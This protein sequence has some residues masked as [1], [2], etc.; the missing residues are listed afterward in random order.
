MDI[1]KPDTVEF[2]E[3]DT[4]TLS[5][6]G[7]TSQQANETEVDNDA[8]T[9]SSSQSSSWDYSPDHCPY[10]FEGFKGLGDCS[11]Y[12]ECKNM[13][14]GE[15][16]R[17]DTG[18]RFAEDR[19]E[20]IARELVDKD[21]NKPKSS[22]EG[23]G[24]AET[25]AAASNDAV[26]HDDP[27]EN[28]KSQ[29]QQDNSGQQ[30][31]WPEGMPPEIYDPDLCP[32]EFTGIKWKDDCSVY[33][34]CDEGYVGDVHSCETGLKFERDLGR[35]IHQQFVGQDYK[36]VEIL[37]AG[38]DQNEEEEAGGGGLEEKEEAEGGAAKAEVEE[39]VEDA[40]EEPPV[41]F[42]SLALCPLEIVGLHSRGDCTQ[43]YKCE[44]GY[45]IGL[46]HS[47]EDGSKFDKHGGEC[48]SSELVDRKCYGPKPDEDVESTEE[49]VVEFNTVD[50]QIA[51][52]FQ[53][54]EIT[55]ADTEVDE[56]IPSTHDPNVCPP[57]FIGFRSNK[58]CTTYYNCNDSFVNAVHVCD[59]GYKL[60]R[61]RGHCISAELVDENCFGPPSDEQTKADKAHGVGTSVA[62]PSTAPYHV[63]PTFIRRPTPSPTKPPAEAEMRNDGL[64]YWRWQESPD[65]SAGAAR[66]TPLILNLLTMATLPVLL[67]SY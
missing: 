63:P 9:S 2:T 13:Y 55:I 29:S 11:K 30:A 21:C 66:G 8:Q 35:C 38:T 43:Y 61:I 40:E 47:C 20:C 17:C 49:V 33:Y 32:L 59:V 12:Y 58:D 56:V 62:S 16:L 22:H 39:E 5:A 18:L 57:E 28:G 53:G 19:A 67:L 25:V 26:G 51:H 50:E 42:L 31:A 44:S 46:I 64:G 15:V 65:S 37:S 4:N 45:L 14:V 52:E 24:A 54:G 10:G 48:I 3:E 23:D 34:E 7:A 1:T 27:L 60:D 6:A 36:S 41:K